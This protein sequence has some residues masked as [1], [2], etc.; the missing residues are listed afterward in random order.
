MNDHTNNKFGCRILQ[1]NLNKSQTAQDEL[2]NSLQ[3]YD[4]VLIQEPWVDRNGFARAIQRYHVIY[5][6]GQE[7]KRL[8]S[9]AVILLSTEIPSDHYVALQIRSTDVVGVDI[10][11]GP[12]GWIRVVNIYNDC[13]HD[14]SLKAVDDFLLDERRTQN[15]ATQDQMIWA[16]DF[17]RHHP[18]WDEERNHHLFTP[19]NMAAAE[20]L[21]DLTDRFGMVMKLEKGV[22]TLCALNTRNYTRVDNVWCTEAMQG[23]FVRCETNPMK[24]PA[25]TDH[26][27]VVSELA[28]ELVRAQV[29][30]RKNFRAADWPAFREALE[31]GLKTLGQPARLATVVEFERQR[32][33]L[34]R[35]IEQVVDDDE[36]IP[37]NKPCPFTKRWWNSDLGASRRVVGKLSR[38]SYQ[39]RNQA[40]HEIHESYR[41]ARNKLAEDIK[42]AKREHWREFLEGTDNNSVFIASRIVSGPGTDGGALRMPTLRYTIRGREVR[43]TNNAE[44][45]QTF[46]KL[47][48]PPPPEQSSVP[49]NPEYPEARWDFRALTDQQIETTIHRLSPYKA[50]KPGTAPNSVFTHCADLLTPYLG[51]LYRATFALK[52]YPAEWA[53][54]DSVVIQ[55]PG[56]GDYTVPNAWRPVT[57]SNGMARVLNATLADDLVAH[58]ERTGALPANHFGGRP[59]RSTMDSIHLMSKTVMDAWR[60]GEVASALFLD[61]KGAFPSVAIDRLEHNLRMAGIPMEY[62]DWVLRRLA[63]R[64]TWLTFDDY[65]S[66][67]FPVSNGLD[68][69]DAMSVILYILYNAGAWWCSGPQRSLP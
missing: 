69:G 41:V 53:A 64:T 33:A 15:E 8:E 34:E 27:P 1:I 48:Y 43:V 67:P 32:R 56:K 5:P 17:N 9:R 47:F 38:T 61:V 31:A 40:N 66:D 4:I 3:G 59:G 20:R 12:A 63:N 46:Y 58:A 2:I 35:V 30:V 49:Q 21:I 62:S 45:A 19:R 57:L 55:K 39:K 26:F 44:K 10:N 68:Q 11:C 65:Q 52:H 50:T 29:R 36:I 28:Y 60:R 23:M 14:R 42:A 54:T 6:F 18:A 7:K 37:V 25:M 24:R 22:P 13:K 51:M 16:G